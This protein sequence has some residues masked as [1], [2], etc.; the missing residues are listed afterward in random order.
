MIISKSG[1]LVGFALFVSLGSWDGKEEGEDNEM[2]TSK[3]GNERKKTHKEKSTCVWISAFSHANITVCNYI[4]LF[5]K[6]KTLKDQR[7]KE[8]G[9]RK[10]VNDTNFGGGS[11][12]HKN[13]REGGK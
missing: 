8:K 10:S 9:K 1:G 13:T 2:W 6:K 5:K 4:F 11:D 12:D 7:K 3:E